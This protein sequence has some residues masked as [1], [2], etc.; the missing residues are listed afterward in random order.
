MTRYKEDILL[1]GF[2]TVSAANWRDCKIIQCPLI[3]DCQK[4][5]RFDKKIKCIKSDKPLVRIDKPIYIQDSPI[6]ASFHNATGTYFIDNVISHFRGDS[7]LPN[8]QFSNL[9]L[10]TNYKAPEKNSILGNDPDDDREL[11]R[12]A[13]TNGG[14]GSI[15]TADAFWTESEANTAQSA[16]TN[17]P[18]L[19]NVFDVI[20]AS[21]FAKND[22]IEI[23]DID[24]K[25]SV[26]ETG[27]LNIAGNTITTVDNLPVVPLNNWLVYQKI[28]RL[29]L[30]TED[31]IPAAIS[32]YSRIKGI[33]DTIALRHTARLKGN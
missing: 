14:T 9:V 18:T 33:D 6:V 29:Y 26:H 21:L 15:V 31:D 24:N 28:N 22:L 23:I 16:I 10:S 2:F 11:S 27:I 7:P 8:L 32:I 25:I 3:R 20:D 5:H 1:Q 12:K 4:K 13:T 17:T 19:K 30:L